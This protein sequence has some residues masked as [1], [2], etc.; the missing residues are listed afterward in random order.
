M[1]D[2]LSK[3]GDLKLAI[4]HSKKLES[5]FNGAMGFAN[6]NPCTTIYKLVLELLHLE[7]EL[8]ED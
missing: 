5:T 6:Q 1:Y 3:Y 2:M 7:Q 8:K 4:K